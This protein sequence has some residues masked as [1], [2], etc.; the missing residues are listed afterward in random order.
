MD[1]F[2]EFPV[3]YSTESLGIENK[4]LSD[5]ITFDNSAGNIFVGD[6]D[7]VFISRE[8]DVS[9][10]TTQRFQDGYEVTWTE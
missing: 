4:R 6:V 7:L 9:G 10:L 2:D 8:Q 5:M 1:F 3:T